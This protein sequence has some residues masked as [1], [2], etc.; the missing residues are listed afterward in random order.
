MNRRWKPKVVPVQLSYEHVDNFSGAYDRPSTADYQTIY[1]TQ[2]EAYE[3]MVAAE[4]ADGNVASA[5]RGLGVLNGADIVEVGLGTGMQVGR[6]GR[7]HWG[8][9]GY[10]IAVAGRVPNAEV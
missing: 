1:E 3:R 6:G 8:C 7:W 4:D 10:G 5:L 2:A 9:R